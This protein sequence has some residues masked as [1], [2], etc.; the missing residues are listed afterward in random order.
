MVTFHQVALAFPTR[1]VRLGDTR[2][3]VVQL[4]QRRLNA[5][6]CGDGT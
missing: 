6:G 2:P 4:I 3:D 1:V 5:A